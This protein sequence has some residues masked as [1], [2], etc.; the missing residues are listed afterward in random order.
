MKRCRADEI[1]IDVSGGLWCKCPVRL[2]TYVIHE[3]EKAVGSG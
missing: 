3:E 1:G 2:M